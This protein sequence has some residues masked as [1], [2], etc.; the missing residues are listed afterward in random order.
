MG[1]ERATTVSTSEKRHA[2]EGS[3]HENDYLEASAAHAALEAEA[4]AP[5]PPASDVD[6]PRG[7]ASARVPGDSAD[8]LR[9]RWDTPRGRKVRALVLRDIRFE[10]S[11][12]LAEILHDFRGGAAGVPGYLD[13]RCIRLEGEN[14]GH[15]RLARADLSGASLAKASL[16]NADLTEARL[17][18]ARLV[19]AQLREADLSRA[20]LTDANLTEAVLEGATVVSAVLG[21]AR[22]IAASF[23]S[24]ALVGADLR[25]AM[26][27]RAVFDGADLLGASVEGAHALPGAFASATH[28]PGGLASV[29]ELVLGV[30]AA[31]PAS[32]G[33]RVPEPARLERTRTGSFV[34]QRVEAPIASEPAR[35]PSS[36]LPVPGLLPTASA[37]PSPTGA[38]R[39]WDAA[40]SALL[41]QRG[42]VARI[43]VVLDGVEKTVYER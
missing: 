31:A 16:V 11:A 12:H 35:R 6:G 21:R 24:A 14:L 13:L 27:V 4:T 1:D 32:P 41:L 3:L 25:G 36:R 29:N 43:T 38:S 10:Q 15:S 33:V 20:D 40:L 18:K 8:V 42:R 5:E 9:M 30:E 37:A 34:L 17:V 19:G 26:L 39:N 28:A 23:R 2:A 22:C 7:A